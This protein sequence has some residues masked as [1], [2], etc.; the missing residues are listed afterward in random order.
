VAVKLVTGYSAAVKG[1]EIGGGA[2]KCV[3]AKNDE[4]SGIL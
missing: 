1:G 2:T 3:P 4:K